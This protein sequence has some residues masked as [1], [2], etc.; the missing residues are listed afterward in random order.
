M[1]NHLKSTADGM[2]ALDVT[3]QSA[4]WQYLSYRV[5]N[6]SAGQVYLHRT[7]GTELAL[8]PLTGAGYIETAAGRFDMQR[9]GVFIEKPSV[10]YLPPGQEFAVRSDSAFEFAFGAAPATGKYPTRLFKPEE[11]RSELRGGG[12]ARRQVNHIL[13]HP[14]P[15]E[16]LILYEVYVPGGAWSGYPPHCHDGYLGSPVLDE[17]YYFRTQP[18]NGVAL[19]RNYRVDEDFDEIFAVRDRDLVLVTQG[20]HATSAAPGSNVYFLNYLAGELLDEERATPP[21][22]D[23]VYAW[24]KDDYTA[25]LMQLPVV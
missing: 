25:N 4:G 13:A 18:G 23:P 19:H 6:L 14:L 24:L 17:T 12:A 20:F 9:A 15:A 10:L 16:R 21:V 7:E 8:V 5:V 1:S 22:D 11:M 2:I 3:P